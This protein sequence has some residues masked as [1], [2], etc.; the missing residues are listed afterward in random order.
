MDVVVALTTFAVIFPAELPDKTFVATLVLSTRFRPVLVWVGVVLAFLVQTTV[1]VTAG[2]L[3]GLLPERAVAAGHGG[4]VRDRLVRAPAGCAERGSRG[5]RGG[6]RDRGAARHDLHAQRLGHDRD[7]LRRAVPGG[8]GRPVAAAHRRAGCSVRRPAVG[9]RRRVAGARL[10]RGDRRAGR[11]RAAPRGQAVNRPSG[12]R[13][14]VR[15][16][17]RPWPRSRRSASTSRSS[18][19]LP[20]RRCPRGLGARA[21][22][23][24]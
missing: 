12:R 13:D 21:D 14:A 11:A 4:A 20:W 22:S 1:A 9:L 15:A 3:L 23:P 16:A 5:R 7:Q 17:R 24:G 18:G 2:G 8:V 10:R 6:A 19:H